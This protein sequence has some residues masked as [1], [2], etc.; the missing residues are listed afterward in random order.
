MGKRSPAWL[1]SCYPER[2]I[3]TYLKTSLAHKSLSPF[4]IITYLFRYVWNVHQLLQQGQTSRKRD[5]SCI[6]TLLMGLEKGEKKEEQGE[7]KGTFLLL[8]PFSPS[9]PLTRFNYR[10]WRPCSDPLSTGDLAALSSPVIPGFQL[11]SEAAAKQLLV[12]AQS[13]R[14]AP[15][16]WTR[17]SVPETRS[18]LTLNPALELLGVFPGSRK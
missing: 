8:L 7:K 17:P 15:V 1:L 9:Q 18:K 2:K 13:Q 14:G 5:K 6:S 10:H 4:F 3:G 16:P 11:I 12:R